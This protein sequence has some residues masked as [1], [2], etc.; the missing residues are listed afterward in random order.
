MYVQG[1]RGLLPI[2]H[3]PDP[4]AGTAADHRFFHWLDDGAGRHMDL[5][6]QVG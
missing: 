4:M 1:K 6:S 3:L 2:E 5:A